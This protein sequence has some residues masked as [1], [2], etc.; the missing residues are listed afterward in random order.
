MSEIS[1]KIKNVTLNEF[2]EK[3][4]YFE[5]V[6]NQDELEA[7]DEEKWIEICKIS[8]SFSI[9]DPNIRNFILNMISTRFCCCNEI[10]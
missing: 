5:K 4:K 1:K 6:L 2:D 9:A 3:H 10:Y 8:S 7:M